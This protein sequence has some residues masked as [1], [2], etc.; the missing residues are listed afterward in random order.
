MG[1]MDALRKAEQKGKELARRG[2]EAMRET[3]ESA[4]DAQR[5]MRQKMRVYP[6][7]SATANRPQPDAAARGLEDAQRNA[8]TSVHGE[9]EEQGNDKKIA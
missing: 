7:R 5:R 2:M 9:A 8:E 6:E 4:E 3:R 1:L